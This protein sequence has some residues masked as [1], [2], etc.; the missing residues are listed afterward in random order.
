MDDT[1]TSLPVGGFKRVQPLPLVR[2]AWADLDEEEFVERL[3]EEVWKRPACYG[4]PEAGMVGVSQSKAAAFVNAL[5]TH[6]SP[7][8]RKVLI[9]KV[10]LLGKEKFRERCR[11]WAI[12]IEFGVRRD[13]ACGH[14]P[15][16]RLVQSYMT[17]IAPKGSHDTIWRFISADCYTGG[18]RC[19]SRRSHRPPPA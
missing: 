10:F 5:G 14:K 13:I 12:Q 8:H 6:F 7:E 19:P 18:K 1:I 15:S 2:L 17:N 9:D 3:A 11:N 16:K 4:R